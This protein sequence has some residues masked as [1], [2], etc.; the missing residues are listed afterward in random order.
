MVPGSSADSGQPAITDPYS[1]VHQVSVQFDPKSR[2]YS[3]LPLGWEKLLCQQFGLPATTVEGLKLD[4]YKSRIPHVLCQMKQYLY[5][6]GG[7]TAEGVFRIAPDQDVCAFVKK[8]LNEN[9]FTSVEDIHVISNLIKVWLR[10]LPHR[11]LDSAPLSAFVEADNPKQAGDA[12]QLVQDPYQSILLW[13]LDLCLDVAAFSA[14][15]KMVVT[16]LAVVFAPNLYSLPALDPKSDVAAQQMAQINATQRMVHFVAHALE[17][18]KVNG[19]KPSYNAA[20]LQ[21]L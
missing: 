10:E 15:N 3:G 2:T 14:K 5:S 11:L 17:W 6:H 21:Q 16:N 8:Q 12:V 20:L 7:L 9:S 13:V 19:Y 18:R 4:Q 1:I